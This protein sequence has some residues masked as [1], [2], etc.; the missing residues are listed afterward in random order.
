MLPPS[1]S[2]RPSLVLLCALVRRVVALGLVRERLLDDLDE[3]V[4]LRLG[5]AAGAVLDDE[6]HVHELHGHVVDELQLLSGRERQ[7][8][9]LQLA[10]EAP[11]FVGVELRALGVRLR[12]ELEHL[13]VHPVAL[14]VRHVRRLVQ[15]LVLALLHEL[16]D[17]KVAQ[18]AL[19]DHQD[20]HR[21]LRRWQAAGSSSRRREGQALVK[22]LTL[23]KRLDTPFN[24][25][26]LS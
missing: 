6:V 21:W 20:L 2:H 10:Q 13:V 9:L 5:E 12:E 25:D 19:V 7:R 14:G 3:L 22:E 26:S 16:K 11:D 1:P 8:R 15:P 17:L 23:H 4:D 24:T 18:R